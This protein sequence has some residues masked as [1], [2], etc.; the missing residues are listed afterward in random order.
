MSATRPAS[1][2]R[3]ASERGYGI[4][5]STPGACRPHAG[6]GAVTALFALAR[7]RPS[8]MLVSPLAPGSWPTGRI[9]REWQVLQST[10]GHEPSGSDPRPVNPTADD[11]GGGDRGRCRPASPGPEPRGAMR[12]T[13]I[14]QQQ[15]ARDAR[16][17]TPQRL[18]RARLRRRTPT[19]SGSP[20]CTHAWRARWHWR[21]QAM[22]QIVKP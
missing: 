18:L 5:P 9:E 21:T 2:A 15:R 19:R 6:I 7:R 22:R 13:L 16:W 20:V 10:F 14:A 17:K 12:A 8:R 4:H 3:S 11:D 1:P